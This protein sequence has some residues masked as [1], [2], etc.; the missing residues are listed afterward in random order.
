M[1]P[2]W[3][4]AVADSRHRQNKDSPQEVI[5]EYLA[6]AKEYRDLAVAYE[7]AAERWNATKIGE[8]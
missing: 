4:I 7:K 6:A 8:L 5:E 2:E 3:T 1:R